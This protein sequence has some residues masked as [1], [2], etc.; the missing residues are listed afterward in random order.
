MFSDLAIWK[1]HYADI[2]RVHWKM[3]SIGLDVHCM[4][5]EYLLALPSAVHV[6]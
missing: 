3:Y 2:K 6:A 4:W 1:A 5:H